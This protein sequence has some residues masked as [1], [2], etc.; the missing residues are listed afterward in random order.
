VLRKIYVPKKEE[1]KITGGNC[2]RNFIIYTSE[3]YG[4]KPWIM[5]W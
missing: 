1:L 2:I 3:N 4:I 5:R